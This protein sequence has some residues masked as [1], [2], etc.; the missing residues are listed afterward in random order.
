MQRRIQEKRLALELSGGVAGLSAAHYLKQNG[1]TNVIVFERDNRVGGK[2][3]SIELEGKIYEL[4]ACVLE[5]SVY[6]NFKELASEFGTE[7]LIDSGDIRNDQIEKTSYWQLLTGFCRGLWSSI[8]Y[9][10]AMPTAGFSEIR[11]NSALTASV[12]EFI[13]REKLSLWQK[14]FLFFQACGYGPLDK[15][16]AAYSLKIF[17]PK[18]VT[19]KVLGTRG[20][21]HVK[22][23]YQ[24]V[25]EQMAKPLTIKLNQAVTKIDYDVSTGSRIIHVTTQKTEK[26]SENA[27]TENFDFDKLIV[28][29]P[30]DHL[31]PLM[32]LGDEEKALFLKFRYFDYSTTLFE[33]E[34]PIMDGLFIDDKVSG[35]KPIMIGNVY[36][37]SASN[38]YNCYAYGDLENHPHGEISTEAMADKDPVNQALRD[39]MQ[40]SFQTKVKI[41]AQKRWEYFPHVSSQDIKDGFFD[42]MES[43]QGV[44]DTYYVGFALAFE[45]VETV[46]TYS[47]DLVS[48]HFPAQRKNCC[49]RG[50]NNT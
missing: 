17:P 47:K 8:R 23:G 14:L 33:P 5:D 6:K 26:E 37:G 12:S 2:C 25:C 22:Q 43:L 13:D 3:Q 28:A 15:V 27:T 38:I 32:A 31:I 10:Y 21:R 29:V 36:K 34:K 16:S 35:N 11:K 45:L 41:H 39:Y 46:V 18:F 49:G 9:T 20:A 42:E 7:Y 40:E 19:S 48:K 30:P 1:Y 4:G 24:W 44:N 50:G